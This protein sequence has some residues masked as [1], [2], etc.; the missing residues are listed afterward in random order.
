MNFDNLGQNLFFD[1]P[2]LSLL[3][4]L[5]LLPKDVKI[6]QNIF[7]NTVLIYYTRFVGSQQG[8]CKMRG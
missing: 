5:V 4:W 7:K 1:L 2:F 6:I 8:T 3:V